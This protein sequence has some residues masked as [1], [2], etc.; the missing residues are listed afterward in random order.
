[1][2]DQ[3]LTDRSLQSTSN[4]SDLLHIVR[5][6][7][8]YK[9]NKSVFL[10]SVTEK[11]GYEGTSQ[12]LRDE[13]ENAVLSGSLTYQTLAE[14]QAV[15]PIPDEGTP[16]KV[17]NDSTDSNNGYY[18]VVSGV[19]VKDS[20]IYEN[21]IEES[22]TTKGV[23]GKSVFDFVKPVETIIVAEGQSNMVGTDAAI[24]PFDVT[25]N[26][27]VLIWNTST[28]QWDVLSPTVDKIYFSFAKRYQETYGGT[29]K[30]ILNAAGGMPIADWIQT[31]T[32]DRHQTLI[33][34]LSAASID[35][36]DIHLW[37]QG[38]NNG[39]DVNYS[40]KL[41]TRINLLEGLSQY[42]TNEFV[43]IFG[44]LLQS[45][46]NHK[47]WLAGSLCFENVI[48]KTNVAYAK[49]DGLIAVTSG[50]GTLVHFDGVDLNK[51]GQRYFEV[52]QSM[53]IGQNLQKQSFFEINTNDS[54]LWDLEANTF[55][56]T[57][58]EGWGQV[59]VPRPAWNKEYTIVNLRSVA[60]VTLTPYE[61]TLNGS[62]NYKIPPNS[63]V[64]IKGIRDEEGTIVENQILSANARNIVL[65]VGSDLT[66][67]NVYHNTTIRLTASATLI[68]PTDLYEDFKCKIDVFSGTLTLASGSGVTLQT[69]DT[70]LASFTTAEAGNLVDI[71]RA[72]PTIETYR[73]KKY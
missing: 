64:T 23:T 19:W 60:N 54:D 63:S 25:V 18:S 24:V 17:A 20:D 50:T 34:Q 10:D 55:I 41:N 14:L 16:A 22:N 68:I 6:N 61:G 21:I 51:L 26:D 42:D 47:N 27:N 36:V 9:Q 49:S 37:H 43:F 2:A 65:I 39:S 12:D 73:A 13:L 53:S 46:P 66:L 57:D 28:S 58:A 56:L 15:S 52:F 35:K 44:G 7:I 4:D 69:Y 67:S 32:I 1:M 59:V 3:K 5:G 62:T 31:G 38:E 30:I 40:Y 48:K 33:D 70:D 71:Y 45:N 11:G 29:V 8:S 72:F